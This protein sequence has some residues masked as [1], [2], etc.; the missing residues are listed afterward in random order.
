VRFLQKLRDEQKFAGI[1]ALVVQMDR[2][3]EQAKQ[4]FA[5]RVAR[6]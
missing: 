3:A 4:Y 1:D 5:R 6:A 2:D